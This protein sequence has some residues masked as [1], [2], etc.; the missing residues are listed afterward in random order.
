MH[1]IL[2]VKMA[3]NAFQKPK[4][5]H[6]YCPAKATRHQKNMLVINWVV[7][8]RAQE[9][10]GRLA[11]SA[12]SLQDITCILWSTDTQDTYGTLHLMCPIN[13]VIFKWG[14]QWALGSWLLNRKSN[15]ESN[16]PFSESW[17]SQNDLVQI[18][19]THWKIYLCTI[20]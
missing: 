2:P 5:Y 4:W 10:A 12:T 15:R 19:R 11:C 3:G 18:S 20:M 7:P 9:K 14:T 8:Q 16:R 1:R 6:L 13:L 17:K